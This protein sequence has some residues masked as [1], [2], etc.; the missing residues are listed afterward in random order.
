LF[1]DE[2]SG[3]LVFPEIVGRDIHSRAL[4]ARL[5]MNGKPAGFKQILRRVAHAL[6]GYHGATARSGPVDVARM[7]TKLQEKTRQLGVSSP[8]AWSLSLRQQSRLVPGIRGFEIRNMLSAGTKILLFDP[9]RLR[10]E[11]PEADLARF[12]VSL[13]LIAWGTSLFVVGLKTRWIE[14]A[15]LDAY[16]ESHPIDEDWLRFL[17]TREVLWN[18]ETSREALA[19]RPWPG[20]LRSLV[21]A[22]YLEPGFRRL[23]HEVP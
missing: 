18:W 21:R 14:A 7:V 9:G 17:V 8:A 15:F 16:R 23:W 5:L 10:L 4:A 1:Y 2:A 6:A 11:P 22:A 12:L 3:M 13:R 20:Y 19:V